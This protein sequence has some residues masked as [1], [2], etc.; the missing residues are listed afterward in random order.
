MVAPDVLEEVGEAFEEL[1][2]AE[3]GWADGFGC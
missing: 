1:C 2:P 3:P